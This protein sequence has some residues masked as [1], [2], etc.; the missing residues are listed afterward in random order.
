MMLGPNHSETR[1]LL[2]IFAALDKKKGNLAF[3]DAR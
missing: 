2:N 3:R 1:K